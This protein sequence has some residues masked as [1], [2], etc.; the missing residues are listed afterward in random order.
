MEAAGKW[1]AGTLLFHPSVDHHSGAAT[2]HC[3]ALKMMGDL[4]APTMTPLE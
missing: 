3:A 2:L 1:K 4:E